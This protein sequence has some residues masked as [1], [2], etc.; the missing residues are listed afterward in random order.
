MTKEQLMALAARVSDKHVMKAQMYR[1]FPQLAAM[2]AEYLENIG[3]NPD[4]IKLVQE[5][6]T[7]SAEDL[8]GIP[9]M[10]AAAG[11]HTLPGWR[12]VSKKAIKRFLTQV[13]PLDALSTTFSEEFIPP[14]T[15]DQLAE[16]VV[17]VYDD[18]GEAEID[19][20]APFNTRNSASS[21]HVKLELH[22]V[23]D[24]IKIEAQHLAKGVNPEIL[25]ESAASRVAKKVMELILTA[26]AVGTAQADDATALIE[27]IEVPEIGPADGKF[28]FGYANQT[29]SE[30]IQP[31]VHAMLID[32]AHYGALKAKDKDSLTASDLDIEFVKKIQHA[33]NLGTN[34]CGV[35]TNKRAAATGFAAPLFMNGAY[36]SVTQLHHEGLGFPLTVATYFDPNVNAMFVVVATLVGIKVTDASAIKVLTTAAASDAGETAAA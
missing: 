14:G 2:S 29:L 7:M 1:L 25:L 30:A 17:P 33:D 32:S 16:L 10:N 24:V 28:N 15:K 12:V 23:D 26:M 18:S 35:I 36:S 4:A 31:E 11:T 13:A 19:S 5:A 21:S 8:A 27:A 20:T 22:L 6:S 9:G 34:A 3:F